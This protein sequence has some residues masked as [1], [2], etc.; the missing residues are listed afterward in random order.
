MIAAEQTTPDTIVYWPLGDLRPN[1]LNPRGD[2]DPASVTELADSIRAQGILQPLLVTPDGT[3]V[4]GH[5][6][7]AA[8]RLAGLADLPAVVRPMSEAAQLEAMLVENL[9]RADLSSLQEARAY[10]R[11]N[12]SGLPLNEIARRLG[13]THSRVQQ[14]L[15]ILKLDP[16]VQ[17]IFDQTDLPAGAAPVLL[18]VA[19]PQM[20][21]RLATMAAG[22]RITIERLRELVQRGQ[23][24]LAGEERPKVAAAEEA[25]PAPVKLAGPVGRRQAMDLLTQ[26]D[27]R[28]ITPRQMAA[29]FDDVCGVCGDCGM[30]SLETVCAECPLPQFVAR[31]AK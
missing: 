13:I 29:L 21:R 31:L 18:K 17:A 1:P 30:A 11:L 9:Q 8:A 10:R 12:K 3:V 5:R 23:G 2:I 19:D 4:A 22:R 16:Q 7:L 28:S 14:S 26:L 27:G 15:T 25:A 6:R 24:V 20:Q